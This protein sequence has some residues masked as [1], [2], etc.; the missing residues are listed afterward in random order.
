MTHEDAGKYSQK[1]PADRKINEN[2]KKIVIEKSSNK[3]IR[4]NDAHDIAA[5]AGC[6]PEEVG[7]V[8]DMLELRLT[9][10]TLGLFGYP[11]EKPVMTPPQKSNKNIIDAL[12]KAVKENPVPEGKKQFV[13]CKQAWNIADQLQV[14]RLTVSREAESRGYK[15]KVCQLGAF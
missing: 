12:D 13:T 7:F 1:H 5:A 9:H 11:D 3:T 8:I 10:C 15:I 4:C 6:A 14:G 2:L